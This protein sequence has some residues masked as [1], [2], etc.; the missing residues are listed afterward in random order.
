MKVNEIQGFLTEEMVQDFVKKGVWEPGLLFWKWWDRNAAQYPD[1][2]AIV[3]SRARLTWTQAREKSI[4]L[5]L[6]FGKLGLKKD[7]VVLAELHN[8]VEAQLLRDSLERAGILFFFVA[9]GF[10]HKEMRHLLGKSKSCAVVV[11]GQDRYGGFDFVEMIEERGHSFLPPA[12][13]WG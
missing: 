11:P 12:E 7:D 1:K 2:E 9:T 6:G 13:F 10:R 4:Q 5:A 8:C 3:D